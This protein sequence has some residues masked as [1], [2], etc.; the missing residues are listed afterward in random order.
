[1]TTIV[2][3]PPEPCVYLLTPRRPGAVALPGMTL[4]PLLFSGPLIE[5]S[6][7]VFVPPPV[8]IPPWRLKVALLD[9]VSKNC[10]EAIE[11]VP[12]V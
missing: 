5:A 6:V 2:S 10:P 3:F 7:F 12:A 11:V 1:L 4:P 9:E 8:R